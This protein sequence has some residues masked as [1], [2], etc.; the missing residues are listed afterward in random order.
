MTQFFYTNCWFKSG[1]MYLR[2]YDHSGEAIIEKHKEIPFEPTAYYPVRS[3]EE[4]NGWQTIHGQPV[5]PQKFKSFGEM[6]NKI[7]GIPGVCGFTTSS[8]QKYAY[9]NQVCPGEISYR[10]SLIRKMIFDIETETKGGYGEAWKDPYQPINAITAW[11]NDFGSVTWGLRKSYEV[12]HNDH[13]YRRFDTE[14]E[15]LHDFCKFVHKEKPDIISGWNVE[16]FDIP[17]VINRIKYLDQDDW[18]KLLSPWKLEPEMVIQFEDDGTGNRIEVGR[19]YIIPGMTTLDYMN[20]YKKFCMS[21]R[22][23]YS[24]NNIAYVELGET[25][26]D[27]S[28]YENLQNLYEKNWKMFIDYNYRDV[29]LVERLDNKL[30]YFDL[31]ITYAYLAKV[32]FYDIYGTVNYWDVKIYNNLFDKKVAVP[33]EPH[34]DKASEYPGGFVKDPQVG[35]HRWVSTFDLNSLYPNILVQCNMSPETIMN[36]MVPD[37]TNRVEEILRGDFDNWMIKS[38]DVAMAANGWCFSKKKQGFIPE[39]VEN[40]YELRKEFKNKMLAA[41]ADLQKKDDDKKLKELI[42][43][44]NAT[45]YALKIALNSLYGAMAN[46]SF[47]YF[48]VRIAGA[49]T[50]TGQTVVRWT[51]QRTNK[52]LSSILKVNKDYI[53]AIDTDSVFLCLEDLIDKFYPDQSD[54]RKI[55]R[56]MDKIAEEKI[57]P[58]MAVGFEE[59]FSYLNGYKQRMVIKRESLADRGIWVAKKKYVMNVYNNEGVEYA[60]P[61]LKIKGLEIVRTS[62]PEMCRDNIKKAVEIMFNGGE[63]A[64][65]LFIEEFKKKFINSAPQEVAFPRSVNGLDEWIDENGQMINRI[66]IHVRAAHVYNNCLKLLELDTKY[67][68][69]KSGEKIKF[70]YLIMPNP[71]HSNVIGFSS[72]LPKELDL[73]DFIDY[74]KQFDKAFVSPLRTIMGAV[75]WFPERKTN[76]NSL[77]G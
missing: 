72:M 60:E 29:H 74:D 54:P 49:I 65:Q 5:K 20:L 36:D 18:V 4:S 14:E 3:L 42:G 68:L 21:P 41:E 30:K 44:Y 26:L 77:F 53:I 16:R 70:T 69:I 46:K 67:E 71:I 62:T 38:A 50:L 66:P 28:E 40:L 56:I 73:T 1:R 35:M 51:E 37:S 10:S 33:P 8:K 57:L 11:I 64:T 47:R 31:A 27:Y 6:R 76:V 13:E 61:K 12:E 63:L 43:Q 23:S 58:E 39:I 48:D 7:E 2:G 25:K 59:L 22:E 52:L 45:Q 55:I 19:V 32:N 34:N 17:Y 15:M 24:L 75:G 9:I